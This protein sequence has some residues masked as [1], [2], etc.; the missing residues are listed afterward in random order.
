MSFQLQR[1]QEAI[2][3]EN[4]VRQQQRESGKYDEIATMVLFKNGYPRRAYSFCFGI[5][6]I[7]KH[8]AELF[9]QEGGTWSVSVIEYWSG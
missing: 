7:K 1:E 5:E 6:D 2:K 4:E 8:A 9:E 3:R